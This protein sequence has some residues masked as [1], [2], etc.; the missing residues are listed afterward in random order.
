MVIERKTQRALDDNF[1]DEFP[2]LLEA[3]VQMSNGVEL[4]FGKACPRLRILS[5]CSDP[6]L[7]PGKSPSKAPDHGAGAGQSRATF[8]KFDG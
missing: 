1:L 8:A 7:R 5:L 6:W 3:D 2:I 4:V